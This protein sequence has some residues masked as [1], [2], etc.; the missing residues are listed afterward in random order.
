MKDIRGERSGRLLAIRPVNT[1]SKG[2]LMWLCKCD[3]GNKVIVRGCYLRQK[4]TK[5]CGCITRIHGMTHTTEHVIWQNMINRCYKRS[6]NRFSDY[7]GRG[8]TVNKKWRVSFV[9]FYED[10]GKRP[11]L[12]HSIDRKNNDGNYNKRNCRWATRS[13][14]QANSRQATPVT[15]HFINYPTMGDAARTLGIHRATIQYRLNTGA[16]GYSYL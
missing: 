4:R 1:N 2:E 12:N 6:N 7:G 13:E 11:S 10:M 9:S 15:I 5:S 8:I 3:C 16:P 14:Q